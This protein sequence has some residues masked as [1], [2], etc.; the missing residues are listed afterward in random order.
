[1]NFLSLPDP[2]VLRKN[3]FDV[4]QVSNVKFEATMPISI[5]N[6]KW[7]LLHEKG[8]LQVRPTMLRGEVMYDVDKNFRIKDR[9]PASGKACV[10]L[11]DRNVRA[12]FIV[13]GT[14]ATAWSSQRTSL[15]TESPGHFAL[16]LFGHRLNFS[17]PNAVPRVKDVLV[18]TISPNQSVLLVVWDSDRKCEKGCCEYAYSL[19]EVGGEGRLVPLGDN[20]YGCD[21]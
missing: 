21:V 17:N 20:F 10:R 12:A 3:F 15:Q 1:M 14:D 2:G 19:Y 4:G 11:G 6:M 8:Y 18:F 9:R 16:S 7:L 13:G 5:S